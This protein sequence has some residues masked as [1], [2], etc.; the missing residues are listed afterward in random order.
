MFIDVYLLNLPLDG[1]D[2]LGRVSEYLKD[3]VVEGFYFYVDEFCALL[4]FI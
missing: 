2:R 3:R 1:E 4:G